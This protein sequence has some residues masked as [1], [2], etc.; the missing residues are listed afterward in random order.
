MFLDETR[1]PAGRGS[2]ATARASKLP[3]EIQI[4]ELPP[5]IVSTTA[6]GR[7][8]PSQ[9]IGSDIADIVEAF[10]YEPCC[11]INVEV[12]TIID[13]PLGYSS[14]A[15]SLSV[16]TIMRS[17]AGGRSASGGVWVALR[18]AQA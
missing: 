8:W 16:M 5:P 6:S 11:S 13:F 15:P 4:V 9:L 14:H 2:P 1:D 10:A 3:S 18:V 17:C 7:S 12:P